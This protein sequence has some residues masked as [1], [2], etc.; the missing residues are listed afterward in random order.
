MPFVSLLLFWCTLRQ[1][2]YLFQMLTM[3]YAR[4][5]TSTLASLLSV[6]QGFQKDFKYKLLCTGRCFS[7]LLYCTWTW[8]GC[9][10]LF[11]KKL[12]TKSAQY[13]QIYFQENIS[14]LAILLSLQCDDI[15]MMS[16]IVERSC[17]FI[18]RVYIKWC[19][20]E[21]QIQF[22]FFDNM[23]TCFI[24]HGEIK[25]P[26]KVQK[27]RDRPYRISLNNRIKQIPVIKNLLRAFSDYLL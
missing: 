1:H 5:S 15:W 2:F 19:R 13:L 14:S 20:N 17:S 6:K 8:M 11:L 7:L 4:K 22:F 21:I 26:E 25:M 16:Q 3:Y 23:T 10:V 24:Q 18:C 27:T 9:C 12:S